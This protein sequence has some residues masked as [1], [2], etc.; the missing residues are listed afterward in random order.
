MSVV[1]KQIK[2]PNE[3]PGFEQLGFLVHPDCQS[4]M[5]IPLVNGKYN[6]GLNGKPE[7]KKYFE[8]SFGFS[9]DSPAGQEF[10]DNFRIQ[11]S[12]SDTILPDSPT[13]R[14]TV[15]LLNHLNGMGF[16]KT[17]KKIDGPVDTFVFEIYDE[18]AEQGDRVNKKTIMLTAASKLQDIYDNKRS[19]IV[20]IAKFLFESASEIDSEVIAYDKLSDY[21]MEFENAK[22]FLK[23]IEVDVEHMDLVATV[24]EAIAKNIIRYENGYYV[25]FVTKTRFGKN[26]E[27]I[28]TYFSN[29]ANQDEYGTGTN[30]A[31][32]T[33]KAQLKNS[34]Q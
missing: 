13:T 14:F 26:P 27:E 29:P 2:K 23:Q 7:L 25:N 8:D 4:E 17:S 34:L 21:I 3:I 32:Y 28:V 12:H 24:K 19:L 22:H 15:H 33:I 16:I 10:L 9:F 1:I 6:I 18:K 30:D 20:L 31:P 5:E 11:I